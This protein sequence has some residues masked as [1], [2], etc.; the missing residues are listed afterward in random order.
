MSTEFVQKCQES[1]AL[2]KK[3]SRYRR[4]MDELQR[5]IDEANKKPKK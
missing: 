5:M 1:I 3:E 4:D 2:M